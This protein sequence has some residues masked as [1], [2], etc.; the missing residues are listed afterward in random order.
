ME[1][2]IKTIFDAWL[3]LVE[4]RK[5]LND[6]IKDLIS[7]ASVLTKIKKPQIRKTFSF[8][9]KLQEDG[10]DELEGINLLFDKIKTQ[11]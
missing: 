5:E 7:E 9:K 4:E 3:I 1:K 10:I 2:K 6:Q 8:L 11:D